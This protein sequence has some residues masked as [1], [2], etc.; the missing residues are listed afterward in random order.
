MIT[1]A[2]LSPCNRYRYRLWRIWNNGKPSLGWIMLNPSTADANLNDATI[3]RCM[4]FARDLGYGGIE[5]ANLYG[6]RATKPYDLK[7]ALDPIGPQNPGHLI[8]VVRA[9][10]IV[11]C[12]WGQHDRKLFDLGPGWRERLTENFPG[13]AHALRVNSDGT[14]A[15]PLYLPGEL[16]PVPYEPAEALV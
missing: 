14:P 13:K 4:A 3:K 6:W 5:V 7:S 10:R 1:G 8:D 11:I 9:S 15:H 12:A 2:F 16:K